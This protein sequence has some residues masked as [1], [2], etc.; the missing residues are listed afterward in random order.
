[1]TNHIHSES[2]NHSEIQNPIQAIEKGINQIKIDLA[3][4]STKTLNVKDL[5]L[6][7]AKILG[8]NGSLTPLLHL[9]RDIPSD[10][11]ILSGEKINSLRQEIDK[12]LKDL[13][14]KRQLKNKRKASKNK[15]FA[16]KTAELKAK[17]NIPNRSARRRALKLVHMIDVRKIV[18]TKQDKITP[19]HWAK[20]ITYSVRMNNSLQNMKRELKVHKQNQERYLQILENRLKS[21]VRTVSPEENIDAEGNKTASYITKASGPNRKERRIK[22]AQERLLRKKI[23]KQLRV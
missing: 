15:V 18:R 16:N 13:D 14:L 19:L 3:K 5:N 23:N 20:F 7:F 6:E 22:L 11:R 4:I 8:K 17:S 2:C 12:V 1:M 21:K 9:L 10:I